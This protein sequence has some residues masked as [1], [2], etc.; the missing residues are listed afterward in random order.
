LH[1][2]LGGTLSAVKM[3]ILMGRDAAAKRSDEKSVARLQRALASIDTGIQFIRRLIEDLRPTLLD[4]LGLE[5]ALQSMVDQFCERAGVL[6]EVSL[7]EG[8]LNLSSAQSTALY[9]ICQESLT[10]VLKYAQAKRV[11][12][13]LTSDG[14]RWTLR[15]TDDGVGLE[16]SRKDR[17]KS[18][19]LIGMRERVLALGGSFDIRGPAGHGTILT[20][21]F[22]VEEGELPPA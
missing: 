3:D 2:E 6:C 14:T 4:N 15:V 5:A 8:E 7:P 17:S 20:A 21:T 16:A 19:G 13:N 1:D 22:P 18:H 11:T 10:N 9:R 12:I